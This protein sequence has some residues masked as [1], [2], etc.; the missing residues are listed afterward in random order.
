MKAKKAAESIEEIAKEWIELKTIEA[1][2]EK[3]KREL[4]PELESYLKDQPDQKAELNGFQFT[5]IESERESFKL[6]D[7]KEKIDGRTLAPYISVSSF[8]QI[9]TTWKGGE[10]KAA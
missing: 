10:K 5:L 6:K 8:T 7:A 9:R 1:N 2:L 4:K 3:K